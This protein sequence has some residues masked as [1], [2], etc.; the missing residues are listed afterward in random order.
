MSNLIKVNDLWFEPF[1]DE[2]AIK[3]KIQNLA[4][5]IN[6]DYAQKNLL[7]LVVLNGSFL[8]AADLVRL[9]NVDLEIDFI[10]V[11]SYEGTQSTGKMELL[12]DVKSN[13]QTKSVLI[14]E[15]I[16][17]TGKTASWL[18]NYLRSKQAVELEICSLILKPDALKEPVNIKYVGFETSNEFLLGYGL[19]YDGK[20]RHLK[21]IYK[22]KSI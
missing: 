8:F 16:V 2:Q 9:L 12:A 17:D 3:Q 14:I 20:G 15:D 6:A 13:I 10:R 19:D 11:K 7:I 1:I 22:Q 4:D 5:Q 18:L 21:Q